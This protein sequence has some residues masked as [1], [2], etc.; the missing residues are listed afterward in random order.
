MF[1]LFQKG[2]DP[3]EMFLLFQNGWD[4]NEMFSTNERQF[5]VKSTY[6]DSLHQY[7]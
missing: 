4:P 5:N 6:D 1:L 3:H 2:W 7:T